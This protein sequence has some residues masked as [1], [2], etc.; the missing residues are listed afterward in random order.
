MKKQMHHPFLVGKKVYLRG[1]DEADLEGRYFQWF[2]D[3]DNTRYMYNGAFPNS[4]AKMRSFF[5]KVTLGNSDIVLAIVNVGDGVHVGNVGLHNINWVYRCA[6]LGIIIG[7]KK[8]QGRGIATEAMRLFLGHAFQRLNLHKVYLLT[9]A[10]NE[11]AIRAFQ[12]VG[13]VQEGLLREDCFRNGK[14]SNSV[15][16]GCLLKDFVR[17]SGRGRG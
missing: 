8:Y 7:E 4:R 3:Q 14:F 16:M 15:Y 17:S 10:N 13:F 11:S 9:D 6:E 5:D 2:N 12:K 1:L